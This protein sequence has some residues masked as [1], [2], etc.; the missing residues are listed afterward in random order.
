MFEEEMFL[1]A[2][3]MIDILLTFNSESYFIQP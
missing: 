1:Q 3:K 2:K